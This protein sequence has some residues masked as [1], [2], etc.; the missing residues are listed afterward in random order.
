MFVQT[1]KDPMHAYDHG[2]AM[3]INN[4][5]V[6]TIHKLEVDLGVPRNI[7]TDCAS[8]QPVQQPVLQ[9]HYTHGLFT[10]IHSFSF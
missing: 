9:A 6:K 10:P 5:I 1:Y 2:V 4:A 8:A 3:H 7:E